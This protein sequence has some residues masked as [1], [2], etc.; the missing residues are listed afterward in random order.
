M[1]LQFFRLDIK[2]KDPMKGVSFNFLSSAASLP[3]ENT[4]ERNMRRARSSVLQ[5]VPE[6]L[7]LSYVH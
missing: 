2:E 4:W 7:M 3:H 6:I 5:L 1:V